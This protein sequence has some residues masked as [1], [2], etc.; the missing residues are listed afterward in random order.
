MT[1]DDPVSVSP[2]IARLDWTREEVILA[3]DFYV[4]CG[5]LNGQPIPGQGSG[6]IAELSRLLKLLSAYP[7]EIQVCHPAVMR[8]W[9]GGGFV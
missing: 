1:F 3:M 9:I 6:E 5:A 4:T 8:L 2:R 7:P